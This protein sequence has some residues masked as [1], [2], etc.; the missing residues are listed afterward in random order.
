MCPNYCENELTISG[1]DVEKVLAAIR[2]L[3]SDDSDEHILDFDKVIPYP[4]KFKDLDQRSA[5]YQ[6]KIN[7]IAK[8]DPE[9]EAKLKELAAEFGV[10]PGTPWLH[11][12][13]NS[14][15]YDWC[16]N[17]WGTKWSA[18]DVHHSSQGANNALIEFLTA[19]TPPLPVIEK[20]ASLFPDHDFDLKYYEGGCGFRGH[21]CWSTGKEKF[22]HQFDYSGPRGG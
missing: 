17:N 2:D 6:A 1:A 5:N 22:H 20:M 9:R 12:G 14:G 18:I 21:A 8:D 11:D 16:V 19:W 7:D 10:E 15:G 3:E 13:F 4:Q